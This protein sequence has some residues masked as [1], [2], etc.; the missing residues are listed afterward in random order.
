MEKPINCIYWTTGAVAKLL[1]VA[2]SAI[3]YWLMEFNFDSKKRSTNNRKFNTSEVN[4]LIVIKRLLHNHP[5]HTILGAKKI[6]AK[7]PEWAKKKIDEIW[8]TN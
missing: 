8:K 6:F 5:Q 2:P 3:R 7:G 4:K 1:H